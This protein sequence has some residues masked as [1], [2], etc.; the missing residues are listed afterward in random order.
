MSKQAKS[1]TTGSNPRDRGFSK[2]STVNQPKST[3]YQQQSADSVIAVRS[4]VFLSIENIKQE[5][6]EANQDWGAVEQK[7][8][9][10]ILEDSSRNISGEEFLSWLSELEQGCGI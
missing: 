9:E 7:A 10:R 8:Y 4:D 2:E 1:T 5:N 6:E 3:H